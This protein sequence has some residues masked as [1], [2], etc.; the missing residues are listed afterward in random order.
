MDRRAF[1]RKSLIGAAGLSASGTVGSVNTESAVTPHV[2]E[3]IRSGMKTGHQHD[4]SE[5]TLRALA[6]FG[7]EHICSGLPSRVLDDNWSVDGLSRLRRH[8]ESF[9]IKLEMVPLP[10]SSLYITEVENP[11]I[12]LGRSPERDHEIEQICTMVLN[13]GKAGIPAL[14][15]NL[16][17]LGVV[18]TARVM[19]RGGAHYS[20]FVYDQA[21]QETTPTEAGEVSETAMWERITYFLQRVVPVAE[22]AKVRI[23]CHPN[24]PGMPRGIGFRGVHCILDTVG[25]L[26]RFVQT[27]PSPYHGLNFC[28]G[29]ISEMLD[30]PGKEIYDVIRWFGSRG[31]IFNVHFRNIQGSYL[32]FQE[33]FPDNGSVDMI[34]A[35]RAY[36]D[37]GY[38][39]MV[40]PDHVPQ[41]DGDTLGAQAFAYC[42]GYIQALL[43]LLRTEA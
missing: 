23:C 35:L 21:K 14:K 39:G 10:M 22:E 8:V 33:T 9:G 36:K 41:I 43:Q 24:D 11:G 12:L 18:R 32:N 6:A 20:S 1:L 19:G 42:F 13:A 37:I 25:G 40:M 26:K 15:Y 31:K 27:V 29:T 2:S 4:H 38:D 7:V 30:D 17:L 28:Q 3:R 5:K 16:T 34:R